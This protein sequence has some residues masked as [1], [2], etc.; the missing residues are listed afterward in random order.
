MVELSNRFEQALVYAFRLHRSQVRKGT[1]IPYIT[2]L[3][4]V[5]ALVLED[6]GNENEAIAAL[7][8]DAIEDQ[9]GDRT[10]QKIYEL[11]GQSVVE[12][13]EG[14]TESDVIPKP[15][16][17]ERKQAH[18]DRLRTASASVR[19]VV[20]ADK[21]HNARSTLAEC[22]QKGNVVWDKFKAGREG[23]LWAYHRFL[24]I[25]DAGTP[26]RNELEQL[27]AELERV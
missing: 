5:A 21:L 11:F 8:H 18:L 6:G 13:V 10:R 16:W 23:A 7:L 25:E 12:I 1:E 17:K 2:H 15:P 22:Q 20:L 3:L 14:C 24:A 27:V 9:G 4:S 19:R 26:M